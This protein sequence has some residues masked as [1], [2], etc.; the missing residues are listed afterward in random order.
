[1][2]NQIRALRP[3]LDSIRLSFA[4]VDFDNSLNEGETDTCT[5]TFG[6]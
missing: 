2:A 3:K 4:A 6:V 1:M 5:F